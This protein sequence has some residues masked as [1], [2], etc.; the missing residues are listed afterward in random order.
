[1]KKVEGPQSEKVQF[2]TK[3]E[4]DL[5][6]AIDDKVQKSSLVSYMV[7]QD[8]EKLRLISST[9]VNDDISCKLGEEEMEKIQKHVNGMVGA[10]AFKQVLSA[11]PIHHNEKEDAPEK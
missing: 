8:S 1:M 9:K 2:R 11:E 6:F 5:D 3:Y 10:V 7:D 4:V